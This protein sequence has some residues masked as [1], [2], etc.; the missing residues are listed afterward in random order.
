MPAPQRP[1]NTAATVVAAR[2]AR[3]RRLSR[4]AD[5][6]RAAGVEVKTPPECPHD[7]TW[8]DWV[9][10]SYHCW[11]CGDEWPYETIHGRPIPA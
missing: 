5:E 7:G 4:Y 2:V 1:N 9:D 6:L 10:D 3:Q 8:L 11:R